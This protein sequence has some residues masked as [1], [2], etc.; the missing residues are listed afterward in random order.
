[1][2]ILK[3]FT[4]KNVEIVDLLAKNPLYLREIAEKLGCSAGQAC[5]TV[6][7]LRKFDFAREKK[8]KNR[9]IISLNRENPLL[10]RIRSLININNLINC[11]SYKN[12][13]KIGKV[14]VYGSFAKGT[15]VPES[16]IDLAVFTSKSLLDIRTAAN[17]LENELGKKISI[18]VLN[19][20][21]LEQLQK[22]DPEFY[23]R[24]KLTSMCLN[25]DIFET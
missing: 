21:K 17:K 22:K 12:L 20:R 9:K 19:K 1:M 25:G 24:L 18:L 14:C 16:D 2:D 11:K 5:K 6:S 23:I 4:K 13:K 3:V 15:D 8:I 7:L 10:A